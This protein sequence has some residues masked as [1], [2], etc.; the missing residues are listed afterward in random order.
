MMSNQTSLSSSGRLLSWICRGVVASLLLLT[1]VLKL[2]AAPESILV[3]RELGTEPWGRFLVGGLELVAAGLILVPATSLI[4]AVTALVV[5]AAALLSHVFVLGIR[6][7]VVNAEG[8]IDPESSGDT[9]LFL[10]AIIVAICAA[11]EVFLHRSRIPGITG[12]T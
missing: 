12:P 9:M 6:T 3:F 7:P 5:M 4:G 11:I 10:L 1:A 2:T 8:V